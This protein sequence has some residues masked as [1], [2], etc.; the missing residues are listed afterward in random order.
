MIVF[1]GVYA[2]GDQAGLYAADFDA[3]AGRLS[4]PRP[5]HSLPNPGFLAL[6]PT[7]DRLYAVGRGAPGSPTADGRIAALA[8]DRSSGTVALV[9]EIASQGKGPCHVA[10]HPGGRHVA[11]ANYGSGSVEVF[12]LRDD[13]AL[14]RRTA[15][16]Q[17]VGA[18]VD[19]ERQAGP[20]AH[21]IK[22]SPD[23]RFALAADL[24]LDKV[25]VYR[26]D[27]AR[28]TLVALDSASA[29]TPPGSGPRHLAFHPQGRMA[30]VV[31]E[32]AGSLTSM[33][34]A[35]QTGRLT[36]LATIDALPTGYA[37]PRAAAET[38]VHP[39]GKFVY[40]SHRGRDSIAALEVIDD[41]G[42]LRFLGDAPS[43]GSWPRHFSIDPTGRWIL[44]ANQRS[45]A[46]AVL[47][48]DVESGRLE[49]TDQ[50]IEAPA[51]VCVKFLA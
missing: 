12:A 40:C 42:A 32:L 15:F 19:A 50:A 1:I 10:L 9:N 27:D 51:P 17:H 11:I 49:T 3:D 6:A 20:H 22:F 29:A 41:A 43:G 34:Y 21:S 14:D 26:F 2:T 35:S 5:V 33:S 25:L 7:A 46:I 13:G 36:P 44:A 31:N 16:V 37:G 18:S 4:A 38:L 23:G 24:G 48:I 8:F 39:T 45:D 47:K 30:F 28:G